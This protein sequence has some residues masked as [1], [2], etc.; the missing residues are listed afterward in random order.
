[1]VVDLRSK[2]AWK[3]DDLRRLVKKQDGFVPVICITESWLKTYMSDSQIKI[4]SY[5]SYRS[6][7][8]NRTCGVLTFMKAF[9]FAVRLHLTISIVKL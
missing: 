1:M 7:R 2:S 3:I 8:A 4:P 9:Q 6:D 5:I